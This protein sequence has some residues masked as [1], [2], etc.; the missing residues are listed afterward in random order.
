MPKIS[1]GLLMYR[2]KNSL[3]VFLVHP[4]GPFWK[5]KNK[6]AWSISKGEIEDGE[7]FLEAAIREFK[8]ETGIKPECKFIPLGSVKQKSGKI[9]HAWAF[10]GEWNGFLMKQNMIEI[11]FPYGSGKKIKIPEIDKADFFN[12]EKAKEKI[13]PAQVEFIKRLEKILREK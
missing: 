8:E 13:I 5:D 1:C 11:E 7:N 4:G 12:L 2:I 10:E 3:E 6:G 9:V